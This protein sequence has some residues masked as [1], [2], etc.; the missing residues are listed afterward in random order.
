MGGQGAGLGSG[1]LGGVGPGGGGL[2]TGGLGTGGLGTG[3]WNFL[4][5]VIYLKLPLQ[6][7]KKINK[8][9][10][11]LL[12]TFINFYELYYFSEHNKLFRACYQVTKRT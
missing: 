4:L 8:Q 1:G 10:S 6:D 7:W 11:F 5:C 3:C 12:F 2:G 9:V